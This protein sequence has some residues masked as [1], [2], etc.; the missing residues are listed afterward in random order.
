MRVP[1]GGDVPIAPRA[2]RQGCRALHR[3]ALFRS[4]SLRGGPQAR[5][6]NPS[7]RPKRNGFPRPLR[8]LGMTERGS[9]HGLPLWGRCLSAHT[10]AEGALRR[11]APSVTAYAMTAPPQGG[12]PRAGRTHRCAP[13]HLGGGP[14]ILNSQ[15]LTPNSFCI[16]HSCILHFLSPISYLHSPLFTLHSSLSTLHS[17]LPCLRRRLVRKLSSRA[18]AS[19]M[20]FMEAA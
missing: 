10:G 20:S 11:A 14:K 16:L 15:S 17:S 19:A 12:E 13:T 9:N 7:L 8:G 5:R 18:T 6:G 1:V 4:S 3:C 2:A